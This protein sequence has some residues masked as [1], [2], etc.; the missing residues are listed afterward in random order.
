MSIQWII[1]GIL[2]G[3]LFVIILVKYILYRRQIVGICRQLLFIRENKTN[4]LIYSDRTEK[5]LL[6]LTDIINRICEEHRDNENLLE[7]KDRRLKMT[8]ENITHDIRTPLTAIRGYFELLSSEQ[9]EEKRQMYHTVID[10]K[11][12]DLTELLEELFIYTRLQ[13]E[14]YVPEAESLDF[15]RLALNTL[16]SF[17]GDFK[18]RGIKAEVDMDEESA[19][20]VCNDVAV[21]RLISNLLK[22]AM[23]HGSGEI[24]IR[25]RVRAARVEFFCENSI[26]N[27]EEIDIAQVFDRFYK[28]DTA[29]GKGS[30]GLG[31]SIAKELAER[32]GGRIEAQIKAGRFV[33]MAGFPREGKPYDENL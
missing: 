11:M 21:N 23:L 14:E 16:L 26:D 5:E 8:F 30:S 32:M 7:A 9:D 3:L 31:L 24:C 25:Y 33:V 13:N 29:R 27:E 17:Y 4:K 28:A 15:T 10:S 1:A 20:V 6:R 2:S 18:K 19:F 12:E 22:N